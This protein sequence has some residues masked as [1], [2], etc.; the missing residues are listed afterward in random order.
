MNTIESRTSVLILS[1]TCA[2]AVI[3]AATYGFCFGPRTTPR[4]REQMSA[5]LEERNFFSSEKKEALNRMKAC[6]TQAQNDY[7]Q[8]WSKNCKEKNEQE[9][10]VCRAKNI[11]DSVC[12][13]NFPFKSDCSLPSSWAHDVEKFRDEEKEDCRQLYKYEI[14]LPNANKEY[15]K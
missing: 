2:I 14:L 6:L 3:L 8:N 10:D 1:G 9:L 15:S 5:R 7:H 11:S 4:E 13:I 12:R